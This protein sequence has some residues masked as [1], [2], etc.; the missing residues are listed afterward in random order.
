MRLTDSGA[1]LAQRV[2]GEHGRWIS[3]I[4]SDL[5]A[6][7]RDTLRHLLAKVSSVGTEASARHAEP[8]G[9]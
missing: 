2:T 1:A 9:E 7:E 5:T 6:T 4:F 8:D 3:A